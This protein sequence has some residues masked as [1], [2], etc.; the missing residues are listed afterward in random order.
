MIEWS[1]HFPALWCVASR[2]GLPVLARRF[3]A[4]T[5][6]VLALGTVPAAGATSPGSNGRIVFGSAQGGT[7]ELY[8]VNADGSGQRR[9][10]WTPQTEQSPAWS[11]D[12]SR[13]AYESNGGGP[14]G[15]WLMNADGSGQTQIAGGDG[16]D[17]AW[18]PDGTLVAFA[19]S[20]SGTWNLW[21]MGAD[22]SGL[23]R[24]S[25]VSATDPAW[26]PSGQ[27][28]AY[29]GRDGIGVVAVDGSGRH[30]VSGPGTPA[31]GPSWSPDGRQIAF[32]RNTAQGYPGELYAANVDGSGERQLTSG[33]FANARASWSPD[34]NEISFQRTNSPPFGWSLWAIGVDG[35][36]LR[37]ITSGA[38]NLAPDWGSSHIVPEP[39]PPDAPTIQIYSPTDGAIYLSGMQ[40]GAFYQCSSYTSYVISC[41]GDVPLARRSTSAR[42][43]RT[44]SP[45]ARSTSRA[46]LRRRA[47]PTRFPT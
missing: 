37:Q 38:N 24:V 9:L 29:A 42:Q 13:I 25:D 5:C 7:S 19:S 33:G 34:G 36:G 8:S 4:L 16:G 28:L 23:R 44:P 15:I 20:R 47:S 17:P 26:S 22:G 43:G 41:Q 35:T 12:G 18:S 40:V 45:S 1:G 3:F 30:L 27:E 39:S 11:P 10:T 6:L 14:F 32:S 46:G 21:V 31:S 2:G